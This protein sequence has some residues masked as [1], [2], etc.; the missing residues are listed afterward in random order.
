LTQEQWEK[1]LEEYTGSYK[2]I[3]K[4]AKIDSACFKE[5]E[6]FNN[7]G[8]M[9]EIIGNYGQKGTIRGQ[10]VRDENTHNG[11]IVYKDNGKW[12]VEPV[13]TFESVYKKRREFEKKYKNVKFFKAGQLIKLGEPLNS[14][15]KEKE[16]EKYIY[17][18]NTLKQNGT[19]KLENSNGEIVCSK[20]INILIEQYGMEPYNP[21]C[22]I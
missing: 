17:T 8:T 19:C 14:E 6:V 18:L 3:K 13:Y 2:K 16:T 4:I 5:K 15:I 22:T 7:D 21:E 10:W 20:T 12:Q 11:Q 9:K 1:F